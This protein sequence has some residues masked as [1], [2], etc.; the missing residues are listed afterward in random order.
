MRNGNL[1]RCLLVITCLLLLVSP[2]LAEVSVSDPLWDWKYDAIERLSLA[3][4]ERTVSN[5]RPMSRLE[6]ADLVLRLS[7]KAYDLGRD[8]DY[9]NVLLRRLEGDLK[10]EIEGINDGTSRDLRIK[11]IRWVRAKAVHSDRPVQLG[12]DYG[13]KGGKLSVRG[14]LAT[15]GT[16][17]FLGYDI[18]P[19]YNSYRNDEDKDDK[20]DLHSG[21]IVAWLKNLE[22]EVGKDAFWWGPGRHGNW[23][24]TNNAP[25][26]DLIKISNAVTGE[27]PF[28]L[29]FM[30]DTKFTAFLGRISEQRITYS[31]N[32]VAVADKKKPLFAGFRLNISPSRYLELGASQTIQ[33]I[34]RGNR[35]YNFDY[36]KKTFLPTYDG[37]EDEATTGP[38]TNRVQAYDISINI[39]GDHDF[40]RALR[41]KGMKVYWTWGG[42]T[43]VWNDTLKIPMTNFTGN[44][45]GLYLDSGKTELRAEYASNY[46]VVSNV[47]YNHYQ[48][49][50]GYVNEG[51]VLGHYQMRGNNRD[52]FVSL[53]RPLTDN[54]VATLNFEDKEWKD[55]S[56]GGT[57]GPKEDIYGFSINAFG[58][59]GGK[60]GVSYEYR[61]GRNPDIT[62]Q[63]VA[64]EAVYR[65]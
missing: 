48:F 54:I 55:W 29:S 31:D 33:F 25:A 6:M 44:I 57:Q 49:T 50:D 39:G 62:N 8:D 60:F 16:W 53:T 35:G 12:N 64:A 7:S 9:L 30:G 61:N 56:T 10:D 14:E 4:G 52:W 27:P 32:G 40:M 36:I 51:F 5:T 26:F 3:F 18:R 65:F 43:M 15:S 38:V 23:V 34:D 59:K 24:L 1:H 58:R 22:I 28:P 20:F 42:E 37:N 63:I 46:D 2:S 45:F 13:F 11:P 21:Y 41:L 47:W 17:G 19:E